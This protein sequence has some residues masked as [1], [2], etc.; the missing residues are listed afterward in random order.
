MDGTIAAHAEEVHKAQSTSEPA[1]PRRAETAFLPTSKLRANDYNAN[2]MSGEEFEQFVTEVRRLGRVPKP[3]VVRSCGDYYEIVDGEHGWRAAVEVGLKDVPCEV[4]DIDDFEARRQSFKRNEHGR[5]NRVLLGRMF[6][7]MMEKRN[8][9]QRALGEEIDVSEGTVRNALEFAEAAQLRKLYALGTE[10]AD[11]I[12]GLSIEQVRLYNR[13]P[14]KIADIWLD[15]GGDAS[16]LCKAVTDKLAR[17]SITSYGKEPKIDGIAKHYERLAAGGLDEFLPAVK[18]AHGFVE[19]AKKLVGWRAWEQRWAVGG[20]TPGTLRPYTRH[21]FRGHPCLLDEAC[22]DAALDLLIDETTTPASF[23]LSPEE[24]EAALR[25]TTGPQASRGDLLDRLRLAVARKTGEMPETRFFMRRELMEREIAGE[26]PDY[27]RESSLAL[28]TR[29]ALWKCYVPGYDE[30]AL[31]QAKRALARGEP[32]PVESG[33][34]I[35]ETI[36]CRVRGKLEELEL[37]AALKSAS[38]DELARGIAGH[39]Y[40]DDAEALP[41]MAGKL[42]A[43]EKDELF[44]LAQWLDRVDLRGTLESLGGLLAAAAIEAREA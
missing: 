2:Q 40:R 23:V 16:V 39:F 43:L 18:N 22:M 35:E 1:S 25:E 26:A 4:V 7:D 19:A 17:M 9:S 28:P 29:Y 3:I 30:G 21:Y 41:V 8:L 42:V 37:E 5:H 13:L 15:S 36:E 10:A 20:L 38:A 34:T 32:M 24:F 27:I 31:D 12:A 11:Q 14:R 33:Q 6:R 44:A